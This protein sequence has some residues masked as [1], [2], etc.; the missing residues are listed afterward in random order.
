MTRVEISCEQ[1]KWKFDREKIKA[2]VA[3]VVQKRY[4]GEAEVGV[5]VVGKTEMKRLHKQY[6][7]TDE[8]TDVLSFPQTE[9]GTGEIFTPGPDGVVRLG[10]IV[11]CYPV[12]V[13]QAKANGKSTD[14]EMGFLAEHGCLHL[15]G[16]HH[17]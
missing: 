5:S 6:M 15:L 10:D 11:I 17:E 1:E 14:E 12:A 3:G 4:P 8:V 13:A 16:V 9:A 2:G 7:E